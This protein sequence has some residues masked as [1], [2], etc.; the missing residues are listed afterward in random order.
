MAQYVITE[1]PMLALEIARVSITALLGR[2]ECPHLESASI[3]TL[4]NGTIIVP[5]KFGKL[6]S[7]DLPA[8]HFR[9]VISPDKVDSKGRPESGVASTSVANEN[10]QRNHSNPDG[11][12][13][14]HLYGNH[15]PNWNG[16]MYVFGDKPIGPGFIG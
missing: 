11:K 5:G 16:C 13:Y 12:V 7:L 10:C 8:V 15:V 14:F 2:N 1:I 4:R 9:T 3:R 6:G